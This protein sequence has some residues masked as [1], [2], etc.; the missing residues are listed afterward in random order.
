MKYALITGGSSGIGFAF[1]KQLASKSYSLL[2]VGNRE[3]DNREAVRQLSHDYPINARYL[4][5]DLSIP[6]AAEQI[7]DFC[8]REQ[9]EVEVLV[10]NA[11]MFFFDA[12]VNENYNRS[13]TMVQLHLTT[14]TLL[15]AMF[16]HEMKKRRNGYILNISSISAWMPYPGIAIYAAGKR[17]MKNFSRSLAYELKD[18]GVNISAICPG[19]VDTDLYSLSLANRKLFRKLGIMHSPD[20]IAKIGVKALFRGKVIVVPGILNKIIIGIV[21]L[22]PPILINFIKRKAKLK[23]FMDN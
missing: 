9:I 20:K 1:S 12:V 2:L 23:P 3:D 15:C 13:K 19:A 11:G 17:Y 7:F 5:M 14:P 21:S 22:V 16:G 18:F 10:N 8:K 6:E 4:T